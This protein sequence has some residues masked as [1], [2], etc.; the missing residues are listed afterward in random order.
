MSFRLVWLYGFRDK[1]AK[2]V[3][4]RIFLENL[5]DVQKIFESFETQT[6][7]GCGF[8]YGPERLQVERLN[9]QP[10]YR[11]QLCGFKIKVEIKGTQ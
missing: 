5:K 6:Y 1:F 4:P 11:R 3:I 9:P 10:K 7:F 2:G 8:S